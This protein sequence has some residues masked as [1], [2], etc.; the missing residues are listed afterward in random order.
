LIKF[1]SS[2]PVRVDTS[3]KNL[4]RHES[5][6]HSPIRCPV[7]PS[8]K[9]SA[10][11]GIVL[12]SVRRAGMPRPDCLP[13]D[14]DIFA[15]IASA[16]FRRSISFSVASKSAKRVG[17]IIRTVDNPESPSQARSRCSACPFGR[18]SLICLEYHQYLGDRA[19]DCCTKT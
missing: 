11:A 16:F 2:L 17:S 10:L 13:R 7:S 4:P 19:D 5:P 18:D 6:Q 9:A 8:M 12:S 1:N 3:P 14:C 15:L